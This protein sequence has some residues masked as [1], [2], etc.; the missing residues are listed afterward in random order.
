LRS[1]KARRSEATGCGRATDL[2]FLLMKR[3]REGR[4]AGAANM[5]HRARPRAFVEGTIRT[6]R[7]R[8]RQGRVPRPRLIF[9]GED[10]RGKFQSQAAAGQRRYRRGISIGKPRSARGAS[11]RPGE[12]DSHRHGSLPAVVYGKP[13]RF[14]RANSLYRLAGK[15]HQL[16]SRFYPIFY[17]YD[18]RCKPLA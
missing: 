13:L 5:P 6:I 18:S 10:P 4:E 2:G 16:K 17:I 9:E 11:R 8:I 14:A 1:K 3:R 12:P 15:P 7:I